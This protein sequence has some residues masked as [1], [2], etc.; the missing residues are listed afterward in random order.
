LPPHPWPPPPPLVGGGGGKLKRE[1]KGSLSSPRLLM[2]R[3]ESGSCACRRL[4]GGK[5]PANKRGQI[6]QKCDYCLGNWSR[7]VDRLFQ[8]ACQTWL[9]STIRCSPPARRMNSTIRSSSL[10]DA[11]RA[12]ENTTA[13]RAMKCERGAVADW[14]WL[15]A[16][17]SQSRD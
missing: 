10:R 3:T 9:N 11:R 1:F 7:R 12:G 8:N 14:F 4:Q 15:N 5:L 2:E 16:H 6:S 17:L 13:L